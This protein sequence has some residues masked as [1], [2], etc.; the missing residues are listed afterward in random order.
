FASNSV[1]PARLARAGADVR[2]ASAQFMERAGDEG[3]VSFRLFRPYLA[4]QAMAI[5]IFAFIPADGW[6]HTLW[7]VAVGWT[8][9]AFVVAGMR[10]HRPPGAAAWYLFG[11]GV[12][13][14][15]TGI[16]VAGIMARLFNVIQE[17]QPADAF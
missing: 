10:R 12:F 1:D 13:L 11:G 6:T 8:A 15:S 14:N 4:V 17:P 5:A 3:G 7:Q 16:L 2:Q 9:A